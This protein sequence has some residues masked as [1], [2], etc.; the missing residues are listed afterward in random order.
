MYHPLNIQD[1][2]SLN[3]HVARFSERSIGP[4]FEYPERLVEDAAF[5][6]LV[7][8]ASEQGLLSA[9][10]VD[11]MGLWV[12]TQDPL[13]LRF[14][15]QSLR[16]VAYFNPALAY[17]LHQFALAY[18]LIR[19]LI[20]LKA[21]DES[22]VEL[23]KPA[24]CIQGH[25]GLGRYA[26]ARYLQG[27][28][29]MDDDIFLQDYFG[30]GH[31][32]YST[33]H[34]NK[35]WSQ[36]LAPVIRPSSQGE[37]NILQFALFSRA[38]LKVHAKEHS[39]GLNELDSYYWQSNNHS[40]ALSISTL[41]AAQS[42]LLYSKVLQLQ[43]LGLSNIAAGTL[44]HGYCLANNYAAQR[45]QGGKTINQ[46]AAV[47]RLLA[48]IKGAY[49][50][51]LSLIE[52]VCASPVDTDSLAKVTSARM[53]IHPLL[54]LGANNAVQVFGGMGYMQ[55]TGAEKILRDCMQLRLMNGTPSELA[56]FL[57]ELEMQR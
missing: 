34:A 15:C 25:F 32:N 7:D 4:N 18:Y 53:Q 43:W 45:V 10:C 54:C 26:L 9:D 2:E 20:A 21:I 19:E 3:E 8:A 41:E 37:Q 28:A 30:D 52:G 55:D 14:S 35:H 13:Q 39:H 48:D 16:E 11:G 12:C 47:R 1:L 27:L 50:T 46:H 6:H 44:R 29:D 31:A 38:Q 36:L 42:Q 51:A 49:D 33:L 22:I 23:S 40:Q 56:L 17:Q 5:N 57:S 24:L